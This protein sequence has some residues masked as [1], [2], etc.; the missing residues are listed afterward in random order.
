MKKTM[1]LALILGML[2]ISCGQKKETGNETNE[3]NNLTTETNQNN[4]NSQNLQNIQNTLNTQNVQNTENIQDGK[5]GNSTVGTINYPEGWN[6]V[7]GNAGNQTAMMIASTSGESITLDLM[8]SQNGVNALKGTELMHS[9]LKKQGFTDDDMS[10]YQG[11]INNYP[12][13]MLSASVE[14]GNRIMMIFIN[15]EGKVYYISI[16]APSETIMNV[17]EIVNSSWSP[18]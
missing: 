16:I 12:A 4:Q 14:N 15:A 18:K 9:E 11:E 3:Q 17:L 2:V 7:S 8:P 6:V 1:L 5:F 10:I 13:Y